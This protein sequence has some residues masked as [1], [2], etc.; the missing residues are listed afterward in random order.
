MSVETEAAAVLETVAAR[1][2]EWGLPPDLPDDV[3]LE[4]YIDSRPDSRPVTSIDSLLVPGILSLD[5]SLMCSELVAK[6]RIR[7]RDRSTSGYRIGTDLTLLPIYRNG[8]RHIEG[9]MLTDV[10]EPAFTRLWPTKF[11]RDQMHLLVS[12]IRPLSDRVRLLSEITCLYCDA[13]GVA[14]QFVGLQARLLSTLSDLAT[15]LRIALREYRDQQTDRT[16]NDPGN[17][18]P[19]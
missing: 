14:G 7:Q 18:D 16:N 1:R 3:E 19:S 9:F 6:S 13:V 10:D 11:P 8:S 12:G 17:T 15:G 4:R 5:F 2:A